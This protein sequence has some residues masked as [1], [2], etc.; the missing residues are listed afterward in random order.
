[1]PNYRYTCHEDRTYT[2]IPTVLDEQGEAVEFTADDLVE[3]DVIE[4]AAN[5]DES[6]FEETTDPVGK[7]ARP[8]DEPETEQAP[9]SEPETAAQKKKRLAAEQA[10]YDALSGE[11]KAAL[12]DL[13][14]DELAALRGA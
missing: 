5:P 9:A 2:H 7:V 11:D 1:M 4:A 14:A 13:T 12:A 3:G 8:G 6:R 10:A